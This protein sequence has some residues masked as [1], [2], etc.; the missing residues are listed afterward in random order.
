MGVSTEDKTDEEIALAGIEALEDFIAE[1]GLPVSL[2]DLGVNENTDLKG[3]ADSC[4]LM[5]SSYKKMT[6]EEILEIFKECYKK[7]KGRKTMKKIISFFMALTMVL[8]LAA[9]STNESPGGSTPEESSS[10]TNESTPAPSNTN[11]KNL[12][13][14]FSMPDNVDDSTVV[15]DGETLGSTQYMAYVIQETVGADIFRIE[16]ETP[17]PTDH[18]ELVDLAKEEQNDN[19]RPK[20]KDTIKNFD[21]YEN[22]FVGYPNWWG[23]MPM[24][25]Y[26][27][28]DEYDFSGKTIIPFNT[29]GGSGFSGTVS[30]IKE[31][32]PN[33][34]V[35]DGKSISRNDIQ[36]AEQEIVDWVNSL[37][38]TESEEQSDSS[39][40]AQNTDESGKTI[41]PF[42]THNGSSSGASSVSTVAELC[43]DSTV[44]T[45]DYFT[46]SGNNVDEAES[47]VDEWLT[48]LGYNN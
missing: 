9:C 7:Q 13:A 43:P 22:I 21:T 39:A 18:D 14:Y 4:A 48:D 8:S 28:F 26:S 2:Q 40:V 41:I 15:I 20:I 46:Y 32:E 31:L 17:Y 38:L 44:L 33:A 27:F 37:G 1:I 34:E 30:T 11:G 42:F 29:H 25:L 36:D 16:P 5:P 47:A 19:A 35:L 3:I 45:D 23:D 10:Q 12:V 24:I 6:H